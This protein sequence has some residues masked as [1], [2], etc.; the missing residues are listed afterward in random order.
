MDA[1][2]IREPNTSTKADSKN[3]E[4]YHVDQTFS[5]DF[6]CVQ[7]MVTLLNM[8]KDESP[9]R[10]WPGAHRLPILPK[11][12]REGTPG[13]YRQITADE[14]ALLDESFPDLEKRF[15]VDAPEG[16]LVLACRTRGK[17]RLKKR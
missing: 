12:T 16:S 2:C 14:E 11:L 9:L 1:L 17:G 8:P 7:G 15:Y 5:F 3:S 6:K 13:N 4:W 10:V